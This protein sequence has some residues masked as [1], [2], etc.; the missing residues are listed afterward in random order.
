MPIQVALIP[1]SLYL[2]SVITSAGL[3]TMY[4]LL[5]KKVSLTLGTIICLATSTALVFLTK[6]T[7]WIMYV[8]SPFIGVAQAITLN[9]G[10]TLIS[11]VIGLKGS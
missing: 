4:R 9:T 2:M 6:E 3:A 11:D 7:R 10:I 5:G 1:L 8:V